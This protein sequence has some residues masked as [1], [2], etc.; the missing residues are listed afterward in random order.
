MSSQKTFKSQGYC[1]VPNVISNELRDFVTQY[2][3]FDEMQDFNPGDSQTPHAH[4]KYADPATETL[5][6]QLQTTVEEATGLTLYPTYSYFRVY[7]NGDDL[8]KHKDRVSCQISATLCFNYS[9]DDTKYQWPIIMNGEEVILS[10]G[11][12]AIYLGN[13]LP[14]W[15]TA[16]DYD[17]NVWQVQGFFHYVDVNGPHAD[18]KYDKRE[19]IGEFRKKSIS[20]KSYITFTK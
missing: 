9:Y 7:R 8:K 19:S 1:I 12:M 15:R 17:E 4:Y 14:H 5:L 13:E 6:L 20:K 10:P 11:D 18:F 3:L 16:L 2:A